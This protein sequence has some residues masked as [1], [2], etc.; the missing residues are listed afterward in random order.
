MCRM[1]L[2]TPSINPWRIYIAYGKIELAIQLAPACNFCSAC[3]KVEICLCDRPHTFLQRE[4]LSLVFPVVVIGL[5]SIRW[6]GFPMQEPKHL[7]RQI[8]WV[9]GTLYCLHE[10]SQNERWSWSH[11]HPMATKSIFFFVRTNRREFYVALV[12]NWLSAS[13]EIVYR[14]KGKSGV[15]AS[16]KDNCVYFYILSDII[17][18]LRLFGK[19]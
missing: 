2:R 10:W 6:K 16:A 17:P 15:L 4:C 12:W 19:Q 8:L 5:D 1:S 11:P 13:C 14:F 9:L 7:F 18:F 3:F